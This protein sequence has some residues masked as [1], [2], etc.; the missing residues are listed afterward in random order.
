MTLGD[1]DLDET[2]A[3]LRSDEG[4]DP[5]MIVVP[6]PAFWSAALRLVFATAN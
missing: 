6:I 2:L 3:D 5:T 4:I 1:F